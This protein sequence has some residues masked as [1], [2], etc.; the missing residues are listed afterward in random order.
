MIITTSHSAP[1]ATDTPADAVNY[2]KAWVQD[3]NI[4]YISPQLYSDGTELTPDFSETGSCKDA[5]CTWDLYKNAF[6]L[7]I[8]SIVDESHY[9]PSVDFFK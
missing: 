3:T 6:A 8:P 4:D 2:V 9:Q 1:Y 7:M 5:G